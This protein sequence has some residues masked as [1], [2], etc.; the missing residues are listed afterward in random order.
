MKYIIITVVFLMNIGCTAWPPYN[1]W[2]K[3]LSGEARLEEARSSRQI[4]V[5]QAKAELDAATMQAE[6]IKI[7]G[8]AAAK[9]PEYRQQMFISA[10]GEALQEG[11]I[12]QIIYVPTEA[13]IPI[14]EAGK[15]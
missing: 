4:L 13:N 5:E 2:S 8:A 15:R 1:V 10:F 9:Y 11:K 7:V 3:K 6:A 12:Q 14:M